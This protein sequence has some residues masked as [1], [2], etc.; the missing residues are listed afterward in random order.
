MV[1]ASTAR[2]VLG[3][4]DSGPRLLPPRGACRDS[5]TSGLLRLGEAMTRQTTD[6]RGLRLPALCANLAGSRRPDMLSNIILDVLVTV[7][8]D[9]INI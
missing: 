5:S 2:R 3:E 6:G 7:S 8:L 1:G 9:G 4:Q